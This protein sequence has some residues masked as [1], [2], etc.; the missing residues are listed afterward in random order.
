MIYSKHIIDF[1]SNI[2]MA[3]STDILGNVSIKNIVAHSLNN[4]LDCIQIQI[5][6]HVKYDGNY[7]TNIFLWKSFCDTVSP[8][9]IVTLPSCEYTFKFNS[10]P[11]SIFSKVSPGHLS[12][13]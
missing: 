3:I 4:Q 10:W 13:F 1:L 9:S 8:I 7:N 5:S 6:K 12:M 2:R 11:D